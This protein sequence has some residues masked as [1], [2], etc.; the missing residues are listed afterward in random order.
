MTFETAVYWMILAGIA[1]M[2]FYFIDE[3]RLDRHYQNGY[4]AG[5]SAGWKSCLDH[6]AKVKAM[7]LDQVFDYDKN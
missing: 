7:K 4:W 1:G 5:R 3:W 2:I 6:Q